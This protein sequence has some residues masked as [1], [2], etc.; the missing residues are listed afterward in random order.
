MELK[1]VVLNDLHEKELHAKMVDFAGFWMPVRYSSDKEEHLCVRE[2]VGIFD[3]SHM[4]E[5]IFKGE[6]ALDLI[7]RVVSNDA[8]ALPIGKAQYAYLPNEQGGIVDDLLVYHLGE[9]EY[10]MVVNASNVEKDWN[11]ISRFNTE[12]VEMQNLSDQTCLFAIQGPKAIATLQPL[13]DTNLSDMPYYAVQRITFAGIP[14]IIFASTGYTKK[15]S[16]S[17]EIF[18]PNAHAEMV[19]KKIMESGKAHQI[20]PIGL[21]ARDTLRLEMGYCL[22][23]NDIDDSTSPFEAGLGWVT[24]FSKQ[25]TN[26]ENLL[27]MKEAGIKRK[28]TPFKMIDKGIPR[29]HY[30]ICDEAGNV[31]GEVT[32]GSLSPVLNIGIGLGYIKTE[33]ATVGSNVY[34]KIR[35]KLNKAEVVKLPF[36]Q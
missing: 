21:G 9:N 10:L 2:D 22:Y 29:S 30:E 33:F 28:L 5:F 24:K 23:G 17:F 18:V 4:G 11:W 32:S 35:E 25:F 6:K 20:K 12:N 3:V 13:T 27:K 34:I 1:K 31:I 15:G 36:V 19:W 14:D 16:G 7:Q 8:S 26:S